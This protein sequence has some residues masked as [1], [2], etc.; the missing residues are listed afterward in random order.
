MRFKLDNMEGKDFTPK[1]VTS[2]L[3]D[4]DYSPFLYKSYPVKNRY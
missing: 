2:M 1:K 3:F 4:S